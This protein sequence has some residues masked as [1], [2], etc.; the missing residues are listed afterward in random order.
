MPDGQTSGVTREMQEIVGRQSI[1]WV[2][3]VDQSVIDHVVEALGDNDSIKRG[4][5]L[6]EARSLEG[7]VV[8]PIILHPRRPTDLLTQYSNPF[9]EGGIP[10]EDDWQ[11][12]EPIRAGDTLTAVATILGFSEARGRRHMLFTTIEYEF[13]NQNERMALI[14]MRRYVNFAPAEQE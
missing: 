13:R 9:T 6:V 1:P 8:S 4:A 14:V 3:T 10:V 5:G 11:F 7:A 2:F 12:L